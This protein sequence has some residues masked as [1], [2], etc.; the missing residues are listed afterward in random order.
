MTVDELLCRIPNK[1]FTEWM[2]YAK[3]EPFGADRRDF[4]LAQI[5]SMLYNINRGTRASAK[6]VLDFMPFNQDTTKTEGLT[7]KAG[8]KVASQMFRHGN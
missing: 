1:E 2:A 3:V 7:G 6:T 4:M 8:A 5:A